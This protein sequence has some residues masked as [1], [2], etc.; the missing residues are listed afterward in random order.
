MLR[1]LPLK[2]VADYSQMASD[3]LLEDVKLCQK[4]V[5]NKG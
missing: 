5:E 2:L 4:I 3:D 1:E